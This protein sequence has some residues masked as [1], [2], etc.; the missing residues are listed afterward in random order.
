MI[1][2]LSTIYFSITL[3]L[4][5]CVSQLFI[6]L[7]SKYYFSNRN[8]SQ[9]Y[10]FYCEIDQKRNVN[11]LSRIMYKMGIL[12]VPATTLFCF[13]LISEYYLIY[14]IQ[15]LIC[16]SFCIGGVIITS[17][18]N[19]TLHTIF[20]FISICALIG[21]FIVLFS[22]Q[23]SILFLISVIS[24]IALT[25]IIILSNKVKNKKERKMIQVITQKIFFLLML[26]SPIL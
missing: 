3:F 26:I 22:E 19:N 11:H 6:L 12:S 15:S 20:S 18:K 10:Q 8:F 9:R 24:L 4:A 7:A 17:D 1:N 5:G 16:V 25:F 21:I 23:E 13:L 2:M 14:M